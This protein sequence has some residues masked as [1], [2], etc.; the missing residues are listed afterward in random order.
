VGSQFFL[1][2]QQT[3]T[4]ETPRTSALEE[5]KSNIRI[6]KQTS[7]E[8][9]AMYDIHMA[10]FETSPDVIKAKGSNEA[11]LPAQLNQKKV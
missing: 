7:T 11:M 10:P 2:A 3:I 9:K 6:L 4:L 1:E 8:K 5:R